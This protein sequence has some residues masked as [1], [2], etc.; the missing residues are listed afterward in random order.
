MAAGTIKLTPSVRFAKFMKVIELFAKLVGANVLDPNFRLNLMTAFI[1]GMFI[2]F[3]SFNFYTMYLGVVIDHN[4]TII[5]QCLCIITVG[6]QGATKHLNALFNAKLIRFICS[7]LQTMYEEYECKNSIYVGHLNNTLVLVKRT[8]YVLFQVN[9]MLTVSAFAI[10]LFY[11]IVRHE[12]IDIIP[13][14]VPGVDPKTAS[15]NTIY[16]IFH[17]ACICFSSFGNYAYD[18]F[19]ILIIVHIPLMKNILKLKFDELDEILELH[20]GNRKKTE[21]LLKDIF[22][23]HQ[24]YILITEAIQQLF[25]WIIFV[26][27]STATLGIIATIVCQFLGNDDLTNIIYDCK[28]YEL[29]APEQ[30]MILIMLRVSQNPPTMTIGNM[31]PLSMNTALQ[32]TKSIYTIAMLLHEFVQ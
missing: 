10:P 27:V 14:M 17:I 9:F 26:Q 31:M 8:I 23:W 22:Q 11:F 7:E 2:A 24:K 19:V 13:L 28:W 15:G 16:R 1:Y 29:T 4:Y 18:T 21:P 32:L 3:F 6:I 5:L 12:E 20:P 25:F 30:K